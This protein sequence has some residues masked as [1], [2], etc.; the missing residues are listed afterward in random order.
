MPFVRVMRPAGFVQP[1][2][3]RRIVPR[4]ERPRRAGRMF[5][6]EPCRLA[7]ATPCDL[8]PR[9][10]PELAEFRRQFRQRLEQIGDQPVVG[11]LKNRR[12]LV[13]VDGND[14]L[15]VLHTGEMLNGA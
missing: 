5:Y 10:P 8:W 13:L 4:P 6:C 9:L 3:R 1:T 7:S 12:L 11:D 15:R 2:V 14:D